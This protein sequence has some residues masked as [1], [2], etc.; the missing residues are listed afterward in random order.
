MDKSSTILMYTVLKNK[1]KIYMCIII[2]VFICACI[3]LFANL[4]LY[5]VFAQDR[6]IEARVSNEN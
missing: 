1:Y 6:H 3:C 4:A 5:S 2:S